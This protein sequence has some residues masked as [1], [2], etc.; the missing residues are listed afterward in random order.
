MI[1][2]EHED[3]KRIFNAKIKQVEDHFTH[4]EVEFEA[5]ILHG[6][7]ITEMT[8]SYAQTI[9]ADLIAIMTEQ[10]AS[11]GLFV[12]PHAQRIVNHSRIPVLSVTPI[13]TLD[14]TSQGNI[15]PFHS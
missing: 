3:E 11:T 9:G 15:R 14:L 7:D 1:T 10:E 2:E 4:N 6:N 8:H 5:N 12:G 13:A